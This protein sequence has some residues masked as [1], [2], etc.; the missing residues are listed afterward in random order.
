MKKGVMKKI[1]VF[2]LA[3]VMCLSFCACSSSKS[4]EPSNT[5]N[6]TTE[7]AKKEVKRIEP[8]PGVWEGNTYKNETTNITF[9]IDKNQQKATSEELKKI[10]EKSTKT[11]MSSLDKKTKEAYEKQ[12]KNTLFETIVL[13]DKK[14]SNVVLAYEKM[15]KNVDISSKKY[16]EL[17]FDFLDKTKQNKMTYKVTKYGEA[18]IAGDKYCTAELKVTSEGISMNEIIYARVQN[19][20]GIYFVTTI[21]DSNFKAGT[22]FMAKVQHIK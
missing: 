18:T 22:D 13:I 3:T 21:A 17:T 8:K 12:V 4:K 15:P 6:K 2:I 16:L 5:K 10:M 7:V 14:G 19:G 20:Y 9:T 11:L 1:A